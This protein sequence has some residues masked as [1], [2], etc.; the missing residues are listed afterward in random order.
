MVMTAGLSLRVEGC[1]F[2]KM[3]IH[4]TDVSVHGQT[5]NTGMCFR[6]NIVVKM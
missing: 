2:I 1:G 4:I 3:Y 5:V 6:L